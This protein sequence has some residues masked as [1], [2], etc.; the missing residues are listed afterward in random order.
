MRPAV[1]GTATAVCLVRVLILTKVRAMLH[2]VVVTMVMIRLPHASFV[3]QNVRIVTA[4]PPMIATFAVLAFTSLVHPV[5]ILV[6][7]VPLQMARPVNVPPA[8]LLV[9][10]V[11][12]REAALVQTV[13]HPSL[14]ELLVWLCV[15]PILRR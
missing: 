1:V 9:Q 2:V 6:L 13:I 8:I 3:L 12:T 4:P 14:T 7:M 11:I 15:P 5:W 10:L